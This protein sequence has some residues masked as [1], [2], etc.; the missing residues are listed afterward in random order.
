MEWEIGDAAG[1]VWRYLEEHGPTSVPALRQGTKLTEQSLLMALGWLAREGNV[2][3]SRDR[4]SLRAA[5]K[6]H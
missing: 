6:P 5:L 3:L 1:T 4:R 2:D